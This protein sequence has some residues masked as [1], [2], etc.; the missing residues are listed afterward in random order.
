M[1]IEV[2]LRAH[3]RG[4]QGQPKY[5]A[6]LEGDATIWGCGCNPDVAIVSLLLAHPD[7]DPDSVVYYLRNISR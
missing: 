4:P 5:H 6:Q 2:C 1:A 7:V 3:D